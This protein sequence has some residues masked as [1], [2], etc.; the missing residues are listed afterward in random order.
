MRRPGL[1]KICTTIP[2]LL[3]SPPKS[4]ANARRILARMAKIIPFPY[5]RPRL[6]RRL[7]NDGWWLESK[8]ARPAAIAF[9]TR[10]L[11]R[12]GIKPKR[13]HLT[14]IIPEK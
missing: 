11:S 14:L 3:N 13:G 8:P 4:P 2:E 9:P 10:K 12:P 5:R 6:P 7:L 1:L